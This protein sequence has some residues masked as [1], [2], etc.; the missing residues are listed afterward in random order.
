MKELYYRLLGRK[1]ILLKAVLITSLILGV[2]FTTVLLPQLINPHILSTHLDGLTGGNVEINQNERLIFDIELYGHSKNPTFI[3]EFNQT[4]EAASEKV[5]GMYKPKDQ[6]LIA[7][8]GAYYLNGTYGKYNSTHVA[9]MGLSTKLF[10]AVKTYS[11]TS[12]PSAEVLLLTDQMNEIFHCFNVSINNVNTTIQQDDSISMEVFQEQFPYVSKIILPAITIDYGNN[13]ISIAPCFLYQI[14]D[15]LTRFDPFMEITNQY[16]LRGF[17]CFEEEQQDVM[18]WSID[19]NERLTKFEKEIITALI[20]PNGTANWIEFSNVHLSGD[21]IIINLVYAFIRGLQIT[22]WGFGGILTCLI[23]AKIQSRNKEK[24]Q[25]A[26]IAGQSWS[27]RLGNLAIETILIGVSSTGIAL[28]V[29]YPIV[30]L[31]KIFK[32]DLLL[33]HRAFLEIGIIA[34][35]AMVVIFIVYIDFE[36]YLRRTLKVPEEEY[37]LFKAIPKYWYPLPFVLVFFLVWVLNRNLISIAVFAGLMIVSVAIGAITAYVLK[38]LLKIGKQLN[39]R[40]KRKQQVP[41]TSLDAL[42]KLWDKKLFSRLLLFSILISIVSGVFIY[43]NFSADGQKTSLL[44]MNGGEIKFE[45]TAINTTSTE[46]ELQAIQEIEK[47]MKEVYIYNFINETDRYEFGLVGNIIKPVNDSNHEG[48]IRRIYAINSTA[49]YNYYES[50]NLQKWFSQGE[51]QELTSN[52][53]FVSH[54]FQEIGYEKD[55]TLRFFNESQTLTIKG[56]ATNIPALGSFEDNDLSLIMDYETLLTILTEYGGTGFKIRYH[57]RCDEEAITQ[58]IEELRAIQ[59]T[60]GIEEIDYMDPNITIGVRI[61]FLRPI[62]IVLQLF[63]ALMVITYLYGNMDE[64]NQSAEAKNLGIIAFAGNYRKTLKNF[65][66]LEGF[67]LFSTFLIIFGILYGV[68]YFLLPFIGATDNYQFIMISRDTWLN[69]LL[70]VL[71]YPILLV[72]QGIAEYRKYRTIDLSIIY[73]HPE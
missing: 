43:A 2:S 16:T 47:F 3:D 58:I 1:K 61:V 24:E 23:F 7:L 62:I 25:R 53:C 11:N 29:F 68:S 67:L 8:T 6:G 10:E 22:F 45:G 13:N 21:E 57:L 26:L 52:T 60:V 38:L 64:L 14:D 48:F 36:L 69:L 18:A 65:K 20:P 54:K 42:L 15:Y 72:M 70:I 17:I 50:W 27:K 30:K 66:I 28:A 56:F 49:F 5:Y 9:L 71:A 4:V 63:I 40:R 35:V 32:I 46:N 33:D 51:V 34:I 44:W 39:E 12:S 37:K 41:L 31:Q 59:E 55:D 73:R 19:A